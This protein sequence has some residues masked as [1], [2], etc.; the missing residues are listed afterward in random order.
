MSRD[1]RGTL[2]LAVVLIGI[3]V[4]VVSVQAA[5]DKG[6]DCLTPAEAKKLGYE[7]CGGV[8][9]SCSTDLLNPKYCY[10]KPVTPAPV[11]V[12]CGEG[13]SCLDPAKATASGYEYCDTPIAVCGYDTAKNPLYCFRKPEP[14]TAT[15]VKC[16][17]GCT[18]MAPEKAKAAG[19]T[20]CGGEQVACNK[21]SAGT[22]MFCFSPPV[23]EEKTTAVP[24]TCAKGCSCIA[25]EK[26]RAAGYTYC[27]GEPIV[28]DRDSKGYPLYCYGK[29]S[30]EPVTCPSTCTCMVQENA[31][32]AG[33]APCGG[34]RTLCGDASAKTP[35]YCYEKPRV[36]QKCSS[37]CSCLAPEKAKAAGYSYCG[38]NQVL[39]GFDTAK[40]SLYCY[41]K[42]SAITVEK[43]S[44]TP[45]TVVVEKVK[46]TPTTQ[47][48][49]RADRG[50]FSGIFD[51][52][53]G[54]R[55]TGGETLC[56]GEC[57]DLQSSADHCGACDTR[58]A[59]GE[60]CHG[61]ACR[62]LPGGGG[63]DC[64]PEWI[65]CGQQCFNPQVDESHCGDC[66]TACP[67]G[68]T[69]Q[70]GTCCDPDGCPAPTAWCDGD[71]VDI[72][73]SESHCGACDTRCDSSEY[74]INGVCG[75]IGQGGSDC[76]SDWLVCGVD[77]VNPQTNSENCGACGNV[78]PPGRE[79][80][81]GSCV[82]AAGTTECARNP[83]GGLT[84]R[85]GWNTICTNTQNDADNCGV[86]G[87]AC[88]SDQ[89]CEDGHCTCSHVTDPCDGV[90][91]NIR[92]DPE[93]CGN[94]NSRCNDQNPDC[95]YGQCTNLQT[96]ENNCGGCSL[97]NTAT[98]KCAEGF[99]CCDGQCVNPRTNPHHCGDCGIGC[100][101]LCCN[102]VC[103]NIQ[104]VPNRNQCELC[105]LQCDQATEFCCDGVCTNIRDDIY[106]CGA[107]GNDC[108][109]G[110]VCCDEWADPE[111]GGI[112]CADLNN[113]PLN[114]GSCGHQC[115]SFHNFCEYGYCCMRLFVTDDSEG[116]L[117]NCLGDSPGA[118]TG[119]VVGH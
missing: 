112:Y 69:C 119:E 113:S 80:S 1:R 46:V 71:C 13:C 86:C 107:C 66:G 65:P 58:C 91:V 4:C 53:F 21:D 28:C 22:L 38:G 93:N 29:L 6:C 87:N 49:K 32:A 57:V 10:G 64:P 100:G 78:C 117:V 111:F 68:Y 15:P 12:K 61:G 77:C 88:R 94:C 55:C 89:V 50:F 76:R 81:G 116:W 17:D 25:P 60:G 56:N 110:E 82:C 24:V 70:A 11:P 26:A 45:T 75:V 97:P 47:I 41:E 106:D 62:E 14:V 118:G 74:C 2:F 72:L 19:Y 79:C 114:C 105:G 109:S 115:G 9:T 59:S 8:R 34:F 90:C 51:T 27:G 39:C 95:C 5:C 54:R 18:C 73:R 92:F 85:K 101:G 33:V 98:K 108:D 48:T 103:T 67:D 40:N 3:A 37:G 16:A 63:I 96:D 36:P 30:E 35:M 43:V 31:A 52:F 104:L 42:I 7:Y 84:P 44:T 83:L 23:V 102:G 99:I 20:Y